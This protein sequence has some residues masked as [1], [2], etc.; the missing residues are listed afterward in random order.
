MVGGLKMARCWSVGA[1]WI[2]KWMYERDIPNLTVP[3][4]V[5]EVLA[6]RER[7]K[8]AWSKVPVL[9]A[10][11]GDAPSS[12]TI[13]AVYNKTLFLSEVLN[14]WRVDL[15]KVPNQSGD[16]SFECKF[17]K[18]GTLNNGYVFPPGWLTAHRIARIWVCP[19]IWL[20]GQTQ[21][22]TFQLTVRPATF[23]V[24]EASHLWG[25]V[26]QKYQGD[27]AITLKDCLQL[28]AE[29]PGRARKNPD[30]FAYFFQAI[31]AMDPWCDPERLFE[32]KP[33]SELDAI[34]YFPP[35][36]GQSPFILSP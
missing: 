13:D 3:L 26:H 11:F 9:R 16:C 20:L 7:Q 15:V 27:A 25:M 12:K 14:N 10:F 28:A 19:T 18:D 23:L 32:T 31:G 35:W 5:N 30:N 2:V 36:R 17:K 1:S 22:E 24:H 4:D 29:K 8:S 34:S 21:V 6:L 33:K